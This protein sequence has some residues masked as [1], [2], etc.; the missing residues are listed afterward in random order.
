RAK[1]GRRKGEKVSERRHGEWIFRY[2]QCNRFLE[3]AGFDVSAKSICDGDAESP[4]RPYGGS[5]FV[6]RD[7]K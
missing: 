3:T 1:V 6:R 4:F 5:L 2:F 7:K